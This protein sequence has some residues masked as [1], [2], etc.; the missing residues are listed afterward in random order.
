MATD[1]KVIRVAI[2]G[3]GR[4]GY[5]I[6]ARWLRTA[7]ERFKVVAV[8]DQLPERRREAEEQLGATTYKDWR[9]LL[10]A[11]GFDLFVNS[12][13]SFL[14][15]TGTIAG[16]RAGYHV[17]CEKP[18]GRTAADVDRMVAAAK[19]ARR[20][21]LP[22]QNSR[23]NPML[24]KMREVI[25][26]G[27]LG[28][29]I[30]IRSNWSGF[31]RRWDWQTFQKNQGGNLYNT[32]PHPMDQAVVLF[33]DKQQPRVFARLA[34]NNAFGG[35]ADDFAEVILYGKKSPTVEVVINSYQAYP[36][37]EMYNV[38]GTFG[39][40]TG[41]PNGLKWKHFDP[42]Q[43]PRQKQ[44]KPW[45]LNRQYCKEDLPWV[46]ES[47]TP[48]EAYIKDGF[49]FLTAG[50][51]ANVYDV[52]VNKAQPVVTLAQVRTQIAAIAEAWRQNPLP[53]RG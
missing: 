3:Q 43:A 45:S 47:W 12:L 52:L 37:G 10:K 28:K 23:F 32:G 49:Q 16:L 35:D 25:D 24:A 13:P 7:P 14:H 34:C 8:A 30:Y 26:S 4:S 22:F 33:G 17:V 11:G 18:F 40:L 51:Y 15:A 46:E 53:K 19:R 31:G 39:G 21:L 50:F 44:W 6:H 20:H 27:V 36:Q 5:D 48:P 38:S 2:A 1:G 41:G 42:K 29:I 9:E